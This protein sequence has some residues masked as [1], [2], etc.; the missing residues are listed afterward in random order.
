MWSVLVKGRPTASNRAQSAISSSIAAQR[1]RRK[2]GK[3]ATGNVSALVPFA[4]WSLMMS[5]HDVLSC[6]LCE[7]VYQ[8]AITCVLLENMELRAVDAYAIRFR[9]C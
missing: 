8:P 6:A 9:S 2:L 4:K 5:D 3:E 1:A 7:F